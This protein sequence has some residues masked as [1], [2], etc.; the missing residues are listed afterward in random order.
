MKD[1]AA[2][3]PC[4]GTI[5]VLSR[6][7]YMMVSSL[8]ELE[9]CT[10]HAIFKQRRWKNLMRQTQES[11]N[12]VRIWRESTTKLAG[13]EPIVSVTLLTLFYDVTYVTKWPLQRSAARGYRLTTMT[14]YYEYSCLSSQQRSLPYL[15][16]HGSS[17]QPQQRIHS[18]LFSNLLRSG[19]P[20]E[21]SS[22]T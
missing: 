7:R 15:T 5:I 6:R 2:I 20:L 3:H 16:I 8:I 19:W 17:A 21:A 4:G 12:F 10:W 1:S 14:R 18:W 13:T 22:N 11:E 9:E